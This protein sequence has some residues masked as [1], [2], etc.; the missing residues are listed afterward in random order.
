[1]AEPAVRASGPCTGKSI[2]SMAQNTESRTATDLE[3]RYGAVFT[4]RILKNI[5]G[6]P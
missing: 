5:R 1:M 3:K 6:L 2:Q 4:K